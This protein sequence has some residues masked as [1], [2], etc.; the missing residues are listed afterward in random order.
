MAPAGTPCIPPRLATRARAGPER[1]AW[2]PAHDAG[3]TQTVKTTNQR[4]AERLLHVR[5]RIAQEA[6]RILAHSG[7]RNYLQAKRKAAQQLGVSDARS[8]VADD[9][10][11]YML[12]LPGNQEV[13]Q[14][15]A[16]YQ[17]LFQGHV[18]PKQLRRLREAAL[19]GMRFLHAFAPKLVGPVLEGT[20]DQHSEVNLHL[21]ADPLELVATFLL[22]QGIPHELTDRRL[23]MPSGE[24]IRVPEF[25]FV[26]GDISMAL[27]VFSGAGAHQPPL[28]PV[29]G[30]PMRRAPLAEVQALLLESA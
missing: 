11:S 23:R 12:S 20:A 29:N 7:S 19:E 27:T 9:V 26:A 15:L 3:K 18:Q 13:E 16:E 30:R 6:A 28:S 24:Y 2:K 8:R 25:R 14:A 10:V 17:R 4:Q 5:Q 21:F 22:E 1:E